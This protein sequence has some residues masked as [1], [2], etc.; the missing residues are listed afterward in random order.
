MD[1]VDPTIIFTPPLG[2]LP[3]TAFLIIAIAGT[4]TPILLMFVLP[5][6]VPKNIAVVTAIIALAVSIIGLGANEA[7]VE[8][9]RDAI[10][11][12]APLKVR[13][14]DLLAIPA[15]HRDTPHLVPMV[16]E[17]GQHIKRW[18]SFDRTTGQ[19]IIAPESTP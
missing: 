7:P 6:R 10:H 17:Q 5:K 1:S 15:E 18:L 13:G 14:I 19:A 4:I 11:H 8:A 3:V 9:M 16:D 12:E 2:H